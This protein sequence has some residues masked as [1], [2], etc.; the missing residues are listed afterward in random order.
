MNFKGG[1]G[2]VIATQRKFM[3]GAKDAN[4]ATED[5]E[6]IHQVQESRTRLC[7]QSTE[8]SV[9]YCASLMKLSGLIKFL[10]SW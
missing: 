9:I 6:L 7:T 3:R 5:K 10:I 8:V 2:G 4:T 1:D